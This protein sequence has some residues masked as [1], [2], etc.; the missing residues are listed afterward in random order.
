MLTLNVLAYYQ[1]NE[2][3]NINKKDKWKASIKVRLSQRESVAFYVTKMDLI[4]ST[5]QEPLKK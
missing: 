2:A 1:Q 3:L 4:P 5:L